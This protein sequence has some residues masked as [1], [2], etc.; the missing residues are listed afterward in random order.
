MHCCDFASSDSNHHRIIEMWRTTLLCCSNVNNK[1]N[2]HSH[3]VERTIIT[4][5]HISRTFIRFCVFRPLKDHC[6]V[7]GWCFTHIVCV[8]R[9]RTE[10]KKRKRATKKHG[11]F[12]HL[13]N[14][15]RANFLK[16]VAGYLHVREAVEAAAAAAAADENC[17]DRSL[18]SSHAAIRHNRNLISLLTKRYLIFSFLFFFV[19]AELWP[20]WDR[21]SE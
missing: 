1:T 20:M 5:T 15:L 11:L 9:N 19:C 13:I 6:S 12:V 21:N 7:L 2:V 4:L 18:L 16:T 10:Q 3:S 14:W 8:H 17:R